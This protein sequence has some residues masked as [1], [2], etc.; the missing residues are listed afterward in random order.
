M[1]VERLPEDVAR[2]VLQGMSSGSLREESIDD[3]RAWNLARSRAVDA[4]ARI[5]LTPVA[6][7]GP[8]GPAG[9]AG[10]VEE[11]GGVWAAF[12]E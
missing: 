2:C 1:I 10:A 12:G 4:V 6:D 8:S 9:P 7:D 5:G 3:P 11:C